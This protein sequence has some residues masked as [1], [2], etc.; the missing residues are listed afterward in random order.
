MSPGGRTAD[1]DIQGWVRQLEAEAAERVS[2]LSQ[3]LQRELVSPAEWEHASQS[4]RRLD[5]TGRGS[6]PA[7]R[8]VQALGRPVGSGPVSEADW[9]RWVLEQKQ[10]LSGGP[11]P[12]GGRDR[13]GPRFGEL[14]HRIRAAVDQWAADGGPGRANRR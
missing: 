5:L 4:Y 8:V 7:Q 9:H 1:A 6:V 14:L 10:R 2:E 3:P 11:G 13:T 12:L